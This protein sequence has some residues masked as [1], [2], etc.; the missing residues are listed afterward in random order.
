MPLEWNNNIESQ[1]TPTVEQVEGYL[2]SE[3]KLQ[4]L[5]EKKIQDPKLQEVAK[6]EL[7]EI[8]SGF[9]NNLTKVQDKHD[10]S[11]ESL[12]SDVKK[13]KEDLMKEIKNNIVVTD[14]VDDFRKDLEAIDNIEEKY[15]DKKWY[16]EFITLLKSNVLWEE[17]E[18]KLFSIFLDDSN[19]ELLEFKLKRWLPKNIKKIDKFIKDF[20]KTS[21]RNEWLEELNEVLNNQEG[22]RLLSIDELVYNR[23]KLDNLRWYADT[24]TKEEINNKIVD[25]DIVIN[26]KKES[27]NE[28]NK[29]K[30]EEVDSKLKEEDSKLKE[31][32][33]SKKELNNEILKNIKST[34][35]NLKQEKFPFEKLATISGLNLGDLIN[36]FEKADPGE[37]RQ[38]VAENMSLYFS[39]WWLEK[40]FDLAKERWAESY[41]KIYSFVESISSF[42][43]IYK[44]K[45]SEI[46]KNSL[47]NYPSKLDYIDK[48]EK[49]LIAY[50]SDIETSTTDWTMIYGD[51]V[52]VD[53]WKQPPKISTFDKNTWY[54]LEI[55][56]NISSELEE[57]AIVQMEVYNIMLESKREIFYLEDK[58]KEYR[59][60]LLD[61][62]I[63]EKIAEE[64]WKTIKEIISD[65]NLTIN[66]WEAKIV[67]L[68]DKY[69][70]K[71][72]EYLEL[73]EVDIIKNLRVKQE[74]QKETLKFIHSVGFDLIPQ[75]ISEEIIKT[76]NLKKGVFGLQEDIDL[77]NWSLWFHE[78]GTDKDDTVNKQR[79][80]ELVNIMLSWNIDKPI[81]INSIWA[82]WSVTFIWED[83]KPGG[84]TDASRDIL[85]KLW[86]YPKWVVLWNMNN[87]KESK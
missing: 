68:E 26:L 87:F 42:S 37:E 69:N 8:L 9:K 79:F 70:S 38:N 51:W 82:M 35:S 81:N 76:I 47:S 12:N 49:P 4:S 13:S 11:I 22:L 84:Y 65:I 36:K 6:E 23:N 60:I 86:A 75:D 62:N 57:N 20:N 33:L 64:Q 3:L 78:F 45:W 56:N 31:K 24:E 7:N 74:K 32:I 5:I 73:K 25:I 83:G 27:L 1:N 61:D 77:K 80:A 72:E 30:I 19:T 44:L 46:L 52:K 58:V 59:N 85:E 54:S 10:I 43:T 18:E 2:N 28:L 16:N 63:L 41:S 71:K 29:E 34:I 39:G 17:K 50:V 40:L 14:L 15:K 66:I 55:D 53:L 48:V 67:E 21:I